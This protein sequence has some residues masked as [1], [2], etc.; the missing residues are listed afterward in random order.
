MNPT[1]P[2]NWL[3]HN[4]AS[5]V[6]YPASHDECTAIQDAAATLG[7]RV[8]S[9]DLGTVDGKTALLEKL[10]RALDFP[11]YFGHNW[12]ALDD[13]LGDLSWQQA[14]GLLLVLENADRLQRCA[15]GDFST[16]L[17]ILKESTGEH[18]TAGIPF[19]VLVVGQEF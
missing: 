10:A 7:Y 16:L 8:V 4:A 3:K 2:G 13:A 9:V 6:D 17:E 11:D 5:G 1:D 18:A 14:P 12:D 19:R 15:P